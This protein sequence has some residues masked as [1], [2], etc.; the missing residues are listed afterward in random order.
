[1]TSSG[2]REQPVPTDGAQRSSWVTPLLIVIAI[3]VLSLAPVPDPDLPA[4]FD[5]L[6]HALAYAALTVALLIA[7]QQR[8]RRWWE[9]LA[10]ATLVAL[11]A[12]ALGATF[13]LAQGLVGRDVEFS[14]VVSDAAGVIAALVCFLGVRAIRTTGRAESERPDRSGG[15]SHHPS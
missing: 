7:T 8:T 9:R 4:P 6:P 5:N 1:M 12:I 15:P 11:G 2:T 10:V 3:A 14:D 13:E